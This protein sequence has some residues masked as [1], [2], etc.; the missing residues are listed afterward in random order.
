MRG[1]TFIAANE[2]IQENKRI[3]LLAS[4]EQIRVLAT[5]PKIFAD[6][7][8]KTCPALFAQL[9]VLK[10][11][12]SG[13]HRVVLMFALLPDKTEHTYSH[14][15]RKIRT[16][17]MAETGQVWSPRMIM[18]DFES[19]M[20][21]ALA[22]ELPNSKHQGC[23]FHFTK[24]LY[25]KIK[26]MGALTEFRANAG[27]QKNFY[28][29]CALPFVQHDKMAHVSALIDQQYNAPDE[30]NQYFNGFWISHARMLSLVDSLDTRTNNVSEGFNSAFGRQVVANPNFWNFL[31]KFKQEE[32]LFFV[33]M[34]QIEE[35]ARP[36][37]PRYI[38]HSQV[39]P[40]F[41]SLKLS[42][43]KI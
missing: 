25:N 24:A 7:T 34:A 5:A 17:V 4:R 28:L 20:I 11:E 8:F 21:P 2:L 1:T 31:K 10:A 15:L 18:T 32:A 12:L 43:N 33:T 42:L 27:F 3:I 30:F 26:E 29:K 16:L 37:L 9:Y 41:T 23:F 6:G 38:I 39:F 19:G 14:M 40:Q 36:P 22:Q 13:G 35:G